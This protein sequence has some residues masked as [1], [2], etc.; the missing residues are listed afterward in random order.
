M[1]LLPQKIYIS[2]SPLADEAGGPPIADEDKDLDPNQTFI[3]DNPLY[4]LI[5]SSSGLTP[6][7]NLN[8]TPTILPVQAG[9]NLEIW[10]ANQALVLLLLPA[11]QTL[12]PP[13]PP[14]P[15]PLKEADIQALMKFSGE[16]TL[17]LQDFLYECSLVF[18]VCGK[19]KA[20]VSKYLSLH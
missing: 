16:E 9:I 3:Q 19:S 14:Q 13:P 10:A 20:S 12:T 11:L 8:A 4:D 15:C 1:Y 7:L 17:K 5:A 6:T 2:L 18:N